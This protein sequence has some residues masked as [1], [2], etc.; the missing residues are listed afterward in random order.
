[1]FAFR[2]QIDVCHDSQFVLD[3]VWQIIK[4]AL[5]ILN[6]NDG[7]IVTFFNIYFPALSIGKAANPFQILIM[8]GFLPLY[9]LALKSHFP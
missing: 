5:G 7:S 8:P 9:V 6:T 2:E 1:M 4:Q 3:F